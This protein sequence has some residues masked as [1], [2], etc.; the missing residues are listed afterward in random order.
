MK[1]CKN[2]ETIS[3]MV[4]S[5]NFNP[6]QVGIE[7]SREH[8]YLVNQMFMMMLHFIGQLSKDY[9]NGSFDGRNEFACKCAD[10]MVE[11]LRKEDLYAPEHWENMYKEI[12]DNLYK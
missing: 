10:K 11:A 1:M 5:C 6:M 4:N 9:N 3:N 8:R 7:L 2:A 12:M